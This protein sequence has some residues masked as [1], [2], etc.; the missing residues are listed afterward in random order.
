MTS[1]IKPTG[2]TVEPVLV[3]LDGYN[4]ALMVRSDPDTKHVDAIH[5]FQLVLGTQ[6]SQSALYKLLASLKSKPQKLGGSADDTLELSKFT[7]VRWK[8][9][10]GRE[11]I[12]A[13]LHT[14]VQTLMTIN[15]SK[16][17]DCRIAAVNDTA[18]LKA[19]LA[20]TNAQ[21]QELEAAE[22]HR[23]DQENGLHAELR[24]AQR[25]LVELQQAK[26]VAE[27][28]MCLEQLRVVFARVGAPWLPR[29]CF[30]ALYLWQYSE[31]QERFS[32]KATVETDEVVKWLR[33]DAATGQA[34]WLR[35]CARAGLPQEPFNPALY[36][37]EHIHNKAHGGADYPINYMILFTPVNN[38]VEFRYG[39]YHLKMI[40]LGRP[41]YTFVMRF[42]TWCKTK[43]AGTHC[44]AF[45]DVDSIP[46]VTL[47]PGRLTQTRLTLGKRKHDS[48]SVVSSQV[49]H[50]TP[51]P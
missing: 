12:V 37:I 27:D 33:D 10:K 14:I 32:C 26:A 38:S 22:Q 20:S 17:R 48:A 43:R 28:D 15:S 40:L 24:E 41:I 51:V 45:M 2:R 1:L 21:I 18:E 47:T 49:V 5:A 13:P 4:P 23:R 25:R 42:A 11:S 30:Q 9:N 31:V 7:R 19:T 16:T 6:N 35:I 29:E 8:G 3:P 34:T 46:R 44:D 39:A 36:Q 50:G